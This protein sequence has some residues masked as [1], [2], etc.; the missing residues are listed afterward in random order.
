MWKTLNHKTRLS[1]ANS[2]VFPEL[3]G[4]RHAIPLADVTRSPTTARGEDNTPHRRRGIP[5]FPH[6]SQSLKRP[7]R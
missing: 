3:D 7:G 2:A 4:A 5:R 6:P 1:P